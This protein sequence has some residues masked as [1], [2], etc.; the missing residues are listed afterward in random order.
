MSGGC[1]QRVCRSSKHKLLLWNPASSVQRPP[2]PHDATA[3][4]L[5]QLPTWNCTIRL[6]NGCQLWFMGTSS[7]WNR[8][9]TETMGINTTGE[10]FLKILEALNQS[11]GLIKGRNVLMSGG[12][13]RPQE[14]KASG[15]QTLCM[16]I[17]SVINKSST[18]QTFEWFT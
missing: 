8:S 13:A 6:K 4:L 1:Q 17:K 7:Y 12:Q 5:L 18:R 3:R 9:Q 10:E 16:G 15:K 2:P 11:W 14:P